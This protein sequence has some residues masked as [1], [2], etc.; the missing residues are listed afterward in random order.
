MDEHLETPVRASFG[1]ALAVI[2]AVSVFTVTLGIVYPYLT[3]LLSARGFPSSIIGINAAM[4]PVGLIIGSIV[5]PKF[6]MRHGPFA[7]ALLSIFASAVLLA[8]MYLWLGFANNENLFYLLMPLCVCLGIFIN[9]LF[10]IGE[11][12]INKLAPPDLRGRLLGV[13]TTALIAGYGVGPI[14]LSISAGSDLMIQSASLLFL[15]VAAGPLFYYFTTIRALEFTTGASRAGSGQGMIGFALRAPYLVL[16]FASIALLDN[17][18]MALMPLYGE[19]QGIGVEKIGLVL[20][21]I[22]IGGAVFQPMIGVL[23]DK[24]SN[25]KVICLASMA[26]IALA[27]VFYLTSDFFLLTVVAFFWGGAAFGT[28][29]MSL[30]KL[31]D[32]HTGADLL[33]G[34]G[35]L[36]LTWGLTTVVGL[37]AVGS[38]IGA[39]DE[40]YLPLFLVALYVPLVV[41]S[42]RNFQD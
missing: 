34:S 25:D 30:K 14:L 9:G 31:G 3:I 39:T 20:G 32:E 42:L 5:T 21:S 23:A 40:V 11:A 4:I 27:F 15:L 17:A 6:A 22:I 1:P 36:A 41:L 26:T 29:T 7:V 13:Y 12:W 16:C 18:A 38:L 10:V 2:V 35:L 19:A 28:Y 33:T 24:S 37:P 8:S